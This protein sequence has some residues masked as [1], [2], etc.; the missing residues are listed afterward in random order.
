MKLEVIEREY[1]ITNTKNV[2][3]ENYYFYFNDDNNSDTSVIIIFKKRI[4]LNKVT[5]SLFILPFKDFFTDEIKIENIT[6]YLRINHSS[7]TLFVPKKE[8]FLTSEELEKLREFDARTLFNNFK[9]IKENLDIGPIHLM[10]YELILDKSDYKEL[11][12]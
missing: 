6:N 5:C 12:I 2:T 7:H 8:M 10:N 4:K 1:P 3:S 9:K 11:N